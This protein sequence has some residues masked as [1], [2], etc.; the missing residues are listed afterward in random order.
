MSGIRVRFVAGFGLYQ[1]MPSGIPQTTVLRLPRYALLHGIRFLPQTTYAH[2]GFAGSA[3]A[4]G[5]VSPEFFGDDEPP[6]AGGISV[7]SG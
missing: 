7:P 5:D 1:G 2:C 3:A 6:L 4:A